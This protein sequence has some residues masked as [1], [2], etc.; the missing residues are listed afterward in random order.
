MICVP[1]EIAINKYLNL[2]RAVSSAR[3]VEYYSDILKMF[4]DYAAE[5]GIIFKH[6]QNITVILNSSGRAN[7]SM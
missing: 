4:E 6:F 7:C 5:Q 1:I 2:H 3:T